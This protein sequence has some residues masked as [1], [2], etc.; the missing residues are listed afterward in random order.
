MDGEE[1]REGMGVGA[2]SKLGLTFVPTS[3]NFLA[4]QQS[5]LHI[6]CALV[7]SF[8]KSNDDDIII[9]IIILLLIISNIENIIIFILLYIS[10]KY[11]KSSAEV[12]NK[13]SSN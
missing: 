5:W 2:L 3:I 11:T 1:G 4:V 13:Y 7:N 12:I 6:A 10:N 8:L 9:F